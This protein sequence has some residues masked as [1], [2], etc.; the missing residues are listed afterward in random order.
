MFDV[1]F[2][3]LAFIGLIGLIVLGPERLPKVARQVGLWVG[4]AR[5]QLS[6]FTSELEREANLGDI[7]RE[8]D[9]ARQQFGQQKDNIESEVGQF[10]DDLSQS[11]SSSPGSRGG[12]NHFRRARQNS[13]SA[14]GGSASSAGSGTDASA[15]DGDNDS[16]SETR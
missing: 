11:A 8:F 5:R 7:R 3:E 13:P 16:D 14:G 12:R 6:S 1:G 10:R 4:R 2:W 9:S 15:A